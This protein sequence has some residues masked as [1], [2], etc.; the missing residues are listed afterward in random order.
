MA[1]TRTTSGDDIDRTHI[2]GPPQATIHT[3]VSPTTQDDTVP[4]TPK[5]EDGRR[6]TPGESTAEREKT[7]GG[8]S[9][10]AE[11]DDDDDARYWQEGEEAGDAEE[12]DDTLLEE[13]ALVLEEDPSEMASWA[14]QPS[15]KGSSE[16]MRMVLLAFNSIGIR[17]VSCAVPLLF[18]H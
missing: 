6:P 8:G 15:V 18:P 7:S 10:Q 14:G 3:A 5:E 13:D 4:A 17:S 2:G 16:V 11:P 9:R 12:D 1:A